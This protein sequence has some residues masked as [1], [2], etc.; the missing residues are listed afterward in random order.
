MARP[1]VDVA[2]IDTSGWPTFAK[3]HTEV[4]T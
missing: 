2:S 1:C 3:L 4:G